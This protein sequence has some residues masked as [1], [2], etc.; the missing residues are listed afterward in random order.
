VASETT[1]AELFAATRESA[2]HLEMRDGYMLDD[3]SFLA[4]LEDGR[5]VDDPESQ[6]WRALVRETVDRGVSV[7]R[8]RIVSEPLSDYIRFEHAVTAGHNIAAGEEVRWLPRRL[9]TNLALPGNDFWLFDGR[10]LLVN[11]FSGNS[12][13]TGME[14]DPDPSAV[15]LCTE[16]FE[17]V[18]SR[19]VSHEDYEPAA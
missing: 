15:K 13:W 14:L 7:R 1:F 8:A 3:P 5:I 10:T 16:A 6:Q 12:D 2:V 11:H 17:A 18:W 9:A 19:A 4:W